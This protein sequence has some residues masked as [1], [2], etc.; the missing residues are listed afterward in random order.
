MSRRRTALALLAFPALLAACSSGGTAPPS[1]SAS[2][3]GG[4]ALGYPVT[5]DNCGTEVTLDAPPER[6]VTIKSSTTELVLALGL[7]DHLIGAAFLDGPFPADLADAGGEVPI[8]AERAPSSEIVLAAEPDLVFAGW[9]SSF[10]ADGLGERSELAGLGVDTYVA[11][12]ACQGEG[13]RPDPLTFESVFADIAE[14]GDLLGAPEAAA[15]LVAEQ[16]AAL[17]QVT[18][19]DEGLTALWYSSGSDT[20]FVGGGIGAPQMI[21]EAAGLTNIAAG[22]EESWGSMGWES[23]VAAEPDVIVLVDSAWNTAENKIS[24]LEGNPVTAALPA[25]QD[26]RYLVV[27]FAATEAGIRNVT[28]AAALVDQL[29]ALP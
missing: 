3:D 11:P 6:I 22:I 10:A 4:A 16:R 13:Y 28:A 1:P 25:V 29:D 19:S 26:S 2:D 7:G 18:P 21:M 23:V 20:P 15:E 12:A 9:E 14:A 27:D 17:E 24:V 8:L 5:V